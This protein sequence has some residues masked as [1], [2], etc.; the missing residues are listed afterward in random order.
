MPSIDCLLSPWH[1]RLSALTH[2]D[3]NNASLRQ[4]YLLIFIPVN[5]LFSRRSAQRFFIIFSYCEGPLRLHHGMPVVCQSSQ[6]V[7]GWDCGSDFQTSSR[8]RNSCNNRKVLRPIRRTWTFTSRNSNCTQG[9]GH[10]R[11]TYTGT[12]LRSYT[13]ELD[14]AYIYCHACLKQELTIC[15]LRIALATIAKTSLNQASHNRA[16]SAQA[17][18]ACSLSW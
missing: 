3:R 10:V 12:Y 17:C 16:H 7:G 15:I 8:T 5:L 2:D 9:R 4:V 11:S 13:I 18:R 14:C 1:S 6:T